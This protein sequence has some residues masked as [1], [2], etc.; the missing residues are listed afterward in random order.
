MVDAAD[1]DALHREVERL[2][3]AAEHAERKLR[4][5]DAVAAVL[6][7]ETTIDGGMTRAL[8]SLGQSLGCAIGGYWAPDGDGLEL[9]AQWSADDVEGWSSAPRRRTQPGIGLAGRV[10]AERSPLGIPEVAIDH[11]LL[12]RELLLAG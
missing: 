7:G 10:W 9:L 3:G 1:V 8:A 4:A 2:R 11:G 6:A 5:L 12:N